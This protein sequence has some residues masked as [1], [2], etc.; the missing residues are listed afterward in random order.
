MARETAEEMDRAE[1]ANLWR[2]AGAEGCFWRGR[3]VRGAV[4]PHERSR[5]AQPLGFGR[6]G[7][8]VPEAWAGGQGMMCCGARKWWEWTCR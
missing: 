4:F 6:A 7:H 1:R 5:R 3:L 2:E 8:V